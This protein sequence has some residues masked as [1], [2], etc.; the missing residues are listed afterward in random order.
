MFIGLN[1]STAD[2]TDDDPTV[3]RCLRF[4]RD[5]GHG[6]LVM[7]NLFA[8]CATAPDEMKRDRSPVGRENDRWIRRL[9]SDA[10]VIVAAWGNHGAYRGRSRDVR[11]MLSDFDLYCLDLNKTG[12]PVHPLYQPGSATLVPYESS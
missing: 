9:A 12:E 11:T 2:E 8:R 5:W 1:P 6:G 10:G 4:A 7:T 3:R